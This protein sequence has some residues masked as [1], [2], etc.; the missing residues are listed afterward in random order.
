MMCNVNSNDA[1]ASPPPH[2]RLTAKRVL[3]QCVYELNLLLTGFVKIMAAGR[4]AFLTGALKQG[5]WGV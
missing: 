2:V 5:Y 1:G 3:S 4:K